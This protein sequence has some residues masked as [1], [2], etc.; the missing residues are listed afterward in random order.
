MATKGH[1]ALVRD[2]RWE[3]PADCS[4]AWE[5]CDRWADG[6]GRPAIRQLRDDG[7]VATLSFDALSDQSCRL[8]NLLAARGVSEGDRVGILL[9]QRPETAIAHIACYRLGA[10][11]VPLFVLFGPDALHFRLADSGA[12]A[13]VTDAEGEAKLAGIRDA[14]P[15]LRTVLII[16]SLPALLERASPHRAH[17]PRAPDD[18]ALIIYTSGTT[19]SPK[20]ALHAHRTLRG[21]L[22]GVSLP[23]HGFPQPGDLIW[24]PADWAWIGGLLDV[25]LPGL[26]HGVPVFSHRFKKFDPDAAYDLM[27]RHQVRNVFIP[28]TALRM[29]AQARPRQKPALRTLTSGGETLGAALL[30]WGRETF[31]LPIN[32]FYGQTEC[33]LVVSNGAP[34]FPIRP[35]SMGRAV[36]GHR[37]AVIDGDGRALPADEPGD[38]AVA[39]PDPVMFLGY[40]NRPEATTAKFRGPWLVTGDTGRIDADGYIHFAGRDD[41]V[42]TSAGYRIGPGPI[43]DCLCRHQAVAMAAVVGRPDALRTEI[44]TAFVVLK[45]GFQASDALAYDLAAFVREKLAAH[46]YPRAIKF[47]DALPTTATGKVMRRVLRGEN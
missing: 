28:P 31:G 21:H 27:A 43:E 40:W 12:V 3:L 10:I 24:T 22:P 4:I 37:V 2:F 29:L 33:N 1:D 19:G 13:L 6:T 8:A 32:E 34:L 23:H 7:S 45:P 20:G 16:E 46:E 9:P 36:P 11:A 44:V 47:V 41:D 26:F 14:L 15:A 17:L 38:I 30:D 18:P 39:S 5:A 42:I 25:L 35:G